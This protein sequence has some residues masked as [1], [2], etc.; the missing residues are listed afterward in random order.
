VWGE[1]VRLEINA[2]EG[3]ERSVDLDMDDGTIYELDNGTFPLE[4]DHAYINSGVY[5]IKMTCTNPGNNVKT[6]NRRLNM[7]CELAP[8]ESLPTPT[9]TPPGAW[10]KVKDTS[11]NNNLGLYSAIPEGAVAFDVS[12]TGQCNA[13]EPSSIACFNIG[14]AGVVSAEGPTDL[15]Y[16]V[17]DPD[18]LYE[19]ESY[20]LN[21][22]LNPSTFI[23]YAIARKDMVV[24]AISPIVSDSLR[25]SL[26]TTPLAEPNFTGHQGRRYSTRVKVNAGAPDSARFFFVMHSTTSKN[27]GYE[28]LYSVN[29]AIFSVRKVVQG[30]ATTLINANSSLPTSSV[31]H[32]FEVDFSS[33][34]G[35]PDGGC[36]SGGCGGAGVRRRSGP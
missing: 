2:N 31:E 7:Y 30:T 18:W 20:S 12:D 34:G 35:S 16:R 4:L 32:L 13:A 28:I 14:S 25:D 36:R 6:C 1:V 29:L 22:L 26:I 33:A 24:V 17:S 9:P 10:L 15:G 27:D 21:K 3:F 11:Y 5:D 23:E 8:P 19:D